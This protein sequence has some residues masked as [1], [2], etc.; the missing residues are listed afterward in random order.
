MQQA[1]KLKCDP[2]SS[3]G[4]LLA[5][6]VS[7]GILAFSIPLLDEQPQ[8]TQHY[9]SGSASHSRAPSLHKK[10]ATRLE[11]PSTVYFP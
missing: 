5:A 11:A 8:S 10:L 4:P 7:K 9:P 3:Y 6:T 1:S 2:E